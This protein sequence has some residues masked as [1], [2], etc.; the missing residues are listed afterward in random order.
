MQIAPLR[1]LRTAKAY[2]V[3][4]FARE[5]A[6]ISSDRNADTIRLHP[7]AAATRA[8]AH[9][10]RR[11]HLPLVLVVGFLVRLP[12][13]QLAGYRDD[14]T[15]F[16]GWFDSFLRYPPADIYAHTPG[17][18]YPPA[19]I[20]LYELAAQ[21][22]RW[23]GTGMPSE[24][25]LNIALKL[26]PI[27]FDL[28]GAA[29]AFA[30]VRRRASHWLA[31]VAAMAIAFNPAV[32]YDSAYWGQNDSIPTVIALLAM[33]A[34]STGALAGAWILLTIAVLVKPPVAILLPLLA[35]Y[36]FAASGAE[37]TRRLQQTALGIPAALILAEALAVM[38]FPHPTLLAAGRHLVRELISGSSYFP[39]NS[40]NAFN[41]WAIFQPFFVSDKIRVLFISLHMW[42]NLLFVATAAVI[43]WRFAMRR[44]TAAIFE[45]STL[46]LF[47]FFL[48]L[49]EMHERY[50]YYAVVFVAA[51][52]FQFAY[53]RAAIVMTLTLLLNLE[54]GLTFMY[55]D[56]AHATIVDRFEFAPWL[57]HLCSITNL[58]VFGALLAMYL[59]RWPAIGAA[60]DRFLRSVGGSR[61][62]V[63]PAVP[64]DERLT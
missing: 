33:F 59:G 38:F 52:V 15:I 11:L 28:A 16:Y 40:L 56:D 37:R 7:P 3:D 55:L 21:V 2:L 13:I 39:Y 6:L 48:F 17:L 49:T 43:Y 47:A 63:L 9:A 30:I 58:L 51:L 45:A 24:H 27:L 4:F 57:I 19:F 20:V 53:R 62:R 26:P 31:L 50:L 22:V 60:Y 12:F 10:L 32:I 1:S 35:L 41:L 44:D 23:F 14:M 18:N 29:V 61:P 36:P 54:Y 64:A 34:L 42:G 8:S 5:C 46:L 25:V